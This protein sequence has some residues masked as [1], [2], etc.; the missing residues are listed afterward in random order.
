MGKIKLEF[1]KIKSLVNEIYESKICFSCGTNDFTEEVLKSL[2]DYCEKSKCNNCDFSFIK[3]KNWKY[4]ESYR[5]TIRYLKYLITV[6]LLKN[7]ITV[8]PN[9][10]ISEI[11]SK[12]IDEHPLL[13]LNFNDFNYE[14]STIKEFYNKIEELMIFA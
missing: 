12:Q 4:G 13:E 10:S 14:F 9:L 8:L 7:S 11:I 2:Y 6:D 1:S 5:L 3:I